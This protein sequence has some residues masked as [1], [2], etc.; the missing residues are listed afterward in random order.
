MTNK[1]RLLS[2]IGFAPSDDNA[3]EGTLLDSGIDGSAA[4]IIS[5]SVPVKRCAIEVMELL[6]T[7]A[8][9]SDV[10]PGF[11]ITYDRNAVLARIKLLK[12][13]IGVVDDSLPVIT[14][15]NVW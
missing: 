3:L 13:E 6:L 4:Y 14:G 5:N 10:T 8:N 11:S 12:Q 15:L 9:T 1:E 2:L 7:T